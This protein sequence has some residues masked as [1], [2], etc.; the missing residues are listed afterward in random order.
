M[1]INTQTLISPADK[2]PLLHFVVKCVKLGTHLYDTYGCKF[3]YSAISSSALGG[4]GG[5]G[6][7]GRHFL[8]IAATIARTYAISDKTSHFGT[9]YLASQK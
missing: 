3:S 7:R 8:K 9:N 1:R 2:A 6:G 4:G 5:G